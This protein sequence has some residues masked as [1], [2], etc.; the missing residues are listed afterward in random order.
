MTA[1]KS[2]PPCHK[3]ND[4]PSSQLLLGDDLRFRAFD[5]VNWRDPAGVSSAS[6]GT[7]LKAIFDEANSVGSVESSGIVHKRPLLID[8]Q[9]K[10]SKAFQ[11][12]SVR[13]TPCKTANP[14]STTNLTDR[15]PKSPRSTFE[16]VFQKAIYRC[17]KKPPK[18]SKPM[19]LIYLEKRP[20]RKNHVVGQTA[21][22]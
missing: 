6:P 12:T 5:R 13:A 14:T 15:S 18:K 19:H 17:A 9:G 20:L 7:A 11:S 10:R 2:E 1:K 21:L 4:E 3:L 16:I 22:G 8:T